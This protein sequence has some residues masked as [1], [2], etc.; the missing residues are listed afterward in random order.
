M[1]LLQKPGSSSLQDT[2][3]AGDLISDLPASTI[4][5]TDVVVVVVVVDDADDDD[6][7]TYQ[8]LCILLS[9]FMR[10]VFSHHVC[11]VGNKDITRLSDCIFYSPQHL[12]AP[13]T[14]R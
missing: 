7:V 3:A 5:R 8:G 1:G 14:D 13:H 12:P 9:M 6:D 10:W 2:K 11:R 4:M